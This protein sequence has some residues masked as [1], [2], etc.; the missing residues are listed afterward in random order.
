MDAT[1][2]F[3]SPI[4]KNQQSNRKIA[5]KPCPD[6]GGGLTSNLRSSKCLMGDPLT[7]HDAGTGA[8]RILA[9]IEALRADVRAIHAVLGERERVPAS[10][11]HI[12]RCAEFAAEITAAIG[13]AA[14]DVRELVD[15]ALREDLRLRAAIIAAT[16]ALDAGTTRRIGRLLGRCENLSLPSGCRVERLEDDR[17]ADCATWRVVRI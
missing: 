16:G 3:F 12:R 5:E 17:P 2:R 15:C 7:L 11:L 6:V 4:K 10:R 14:F 13:D 1:Q 9:A 8:E